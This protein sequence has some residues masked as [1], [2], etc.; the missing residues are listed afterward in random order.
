M[1]GE[2]AKRRLIL[3]HR[4]SFAASLALSLLSSYSLTIPYLLL[5]DLCVSFSLRTLHISVLYL[6]F[7]G[8]IYARCFFPPSSIGSATKQFGNKASKKHL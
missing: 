6:L 2:K 8:P 3:V 1:I 5:G 4:F 7:M